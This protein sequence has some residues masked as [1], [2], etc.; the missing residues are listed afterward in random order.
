M[1]NQTLEVSSLFL[2]PKKLETVQL[3]INRKMDLKTLAYSIMEYY[4]IRKG[5][6]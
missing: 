6:K 3:S 5:K 2:I 4:S 1:P